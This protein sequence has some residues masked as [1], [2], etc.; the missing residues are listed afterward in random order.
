MDRYSH[1]KA[2][3]RLLI[4][5]PDGTPA[6]G[7]TVRADQTAHEFLFGCS[8]FDAVEMMK[9]LLPAEARSVSG[10]CRRSAEP[11]TGHKPEKK[12]SDKEEQTWETIIRVDL[13][14]RERPAMR[15]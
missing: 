8:A 3:A 13:H 12:D 7:Q 6:A 2:E 5:K 15:N 4:L 1:R 10:S 14:F 11:G 9:T